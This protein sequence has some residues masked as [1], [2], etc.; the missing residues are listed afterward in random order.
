[1]LPLQIILILG[2]LFLLVLCCMIAAQL[3]TRP[4]PITDDEVVRTSEAAWA[5]P[6]DRRLS[7][8][9]GEIRRSNLVRL[10]NLREV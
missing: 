10:S 7:D 1:M 2:I 9:G 6:R 5:V 8:G 3:A 4:M